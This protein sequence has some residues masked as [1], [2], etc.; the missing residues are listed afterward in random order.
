MR[1][2][3]SV[4]MKFTKHWRVLN[5]TNY[6]DAPLKGRERQALLPFST[7]LKSGFLWNL[8]RYQCQCRF[9]HAYISTR[10]MGILT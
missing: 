5:R 4:M 8:I 7:H 9:Q 2:R 1:G 3:F 6:S 10:F